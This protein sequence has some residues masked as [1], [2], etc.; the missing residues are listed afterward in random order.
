MLFNQALQALCGQGGHCFKAGEMPLEAR[1]IGS[2][3]HLAGC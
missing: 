3:P 2:R 1:I